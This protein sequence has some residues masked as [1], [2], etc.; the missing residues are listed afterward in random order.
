MEF[1]PLEH[2]GH[3]A[4]VR[5]CL[6]CHGAD[7]AQITFPASISEERFLSVLRNGG[8]EMPPFTERRL[9]PKVVKYLIAYLRNPAADESST[10]NVKDA[11][12]PPPSGQARYFGPFGSVL[13]A[14]NGLVAMRPPW[15][16]V[17]AYD[18]N[19]G[20]IKWRFPLGTTP[21]LAAKGIKNTGSSSLLRNGPV[22]TAGGLIFIASQ[23][24]RMIHAYDKDTGKLLWETEIDAN[25]DGIPAVYETDGREYVAFFAASAQGQAQGP[26]PIQESGRDFVFKAAKPGSQ[27]YYVFALPQKKLNSQN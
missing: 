12:N 2:R 18:L 13:F 11:A 25:P 3:A 24:D 26:A 14:N 9:P 6:P 8:K 1:G 27:G 17:V 5:N 21:G 23:A 4:Y 22:V 19:E 20:T 15:C 7:R 10:V 16:E